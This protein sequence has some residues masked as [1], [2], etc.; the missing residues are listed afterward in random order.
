M[1]EMFY[2]GYAILRKFTFGMGSFGN[3]KILSSGEIHEVL[4]AAENKSSFS[5]E[6]RQVIVCLIDMEIRIE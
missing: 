1:N 2:E 3:Q 4:K 5:D 6:D